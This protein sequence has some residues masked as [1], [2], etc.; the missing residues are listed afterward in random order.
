MKKKY[1]ILFVLFLFIPLSIVAWFFSQGQE[2][3]E[4]Y[5]REELHVMMERIFQA[6]I[7]GMEKE[8]SDAFN[9]CLAKL[10]HLN[11]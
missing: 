2:S 8:L 11:P 9:A 6:P 5:T 1:I 7:E 3:E 4:N 10:W